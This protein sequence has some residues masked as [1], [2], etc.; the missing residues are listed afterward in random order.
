MGQPLGSGDII[1][2]SGK[3]TTVGAR[4]RGAERVANLTNRPS[5]GRPTLIVVWPS[6][7]T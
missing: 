5:E 1:E 7:A 3:V 4:S 6:D 2:E